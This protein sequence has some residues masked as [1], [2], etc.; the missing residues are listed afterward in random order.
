MVAGGRP[1]QR[2][3]ITS[4]IF[5]KDAAHFQVGAQHPLAGDLGHLQ[6]LIG[7]GYSAGGAGGT[8]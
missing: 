1:S 7:A 4:Q 8:G 3:V 5:W 2:L 6:A